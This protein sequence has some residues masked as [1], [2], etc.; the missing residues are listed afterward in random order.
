[1]ASLA[2]RAVVNLL[3]RSPFNPR[4]TGEPDDAVVELVEGP[5]ALPPGRALDLGCGSGRHA[6]YLAKHGWDATGV[7]LVADAVAQAR[8]RA[9][10]EGVAPR[11]IQG[12]VAELGKLGVP[13]G[14][15][16]VVDAG[17]FHG[18]PSRMRDAYVPEVT[19]L[20]APGAL[21]LL[22]GLAKHPVLKGVQKDEL[23]RRFTQWRLIRA[24]S[25]AGAE[26]LRY[27]DGNPMLR[28]AFEKGWFDPWRY[29]LRR[30][31]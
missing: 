7:D 24:E 10:T 13:G 25:V 29:L 17:C 1:M 23:T 16:L 19:R 6:V 2:T 4:S 27:G 28:R 12:D 20:A 14:N 5:D 9:V 3:Y 18:L 8:N 26:M 31:S 30:E 15:N 22:L 21:L 11:L